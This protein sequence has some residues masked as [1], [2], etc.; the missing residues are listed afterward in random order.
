NNKKENVSTSNTKT[1]SEN[2]NTQS[3]DHGYGLKSLEELFE[4]NIE[5][6]PEK[7]VDRNCYPLA[8]LWCTWNW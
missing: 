4:V 3:P 2:I 8:L 6:T 1:A 5:S 7:I